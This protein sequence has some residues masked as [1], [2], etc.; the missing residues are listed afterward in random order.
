MFM[1]VGLPSKTYCLLDGRHTNIWSTTS[2]VKGSTL[3]SKMVLE[4]VS[5]TSERVVYKYTPEGASERLDLQLLHVS[6]DVE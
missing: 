6:R 3:N 4:Q 2:R 5:S 1:C